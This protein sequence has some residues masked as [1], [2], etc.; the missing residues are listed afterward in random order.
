MYTYNPCAT[1]RFKY[2][3]KAYPDEF[4]TC[5]NTTCN[6]LPISSQQECI[7]QCNNCFPGGT[8]GSNVQTKFASC[9]EYHTDENLPNVMNCCLKSCNSDD[10]TCQQACI[11]TYN[12]LLSSN[13]KEEYALLQPDNISFWMIILISLFILLFIR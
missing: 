13:I 12:A 2:E 6:Q 1:C 7:E 8:G 10:Y 5:C 4:A 3:N 9:L 11:D